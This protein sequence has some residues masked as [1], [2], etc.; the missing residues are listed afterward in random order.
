[1]GAD[2]PVQTP[3][4]D[5][6]LREASALTSAL[7]RARVVRRLL[8]LAV[9]IFV[10]A[11]G[12]AIYNEANHFMSPKYRDDL[13]NVAQE[14]LKAN[15]DKYMHHVQDLYEKNYPI[16]TEAF[17]TQAKQDM[18][19]FLQE[20]EKER[21]TLSD[22]LQAELQKRLDK[23]YET[24]VAK[25]QKTIEQELPGAK[26]E[27][28][29]EKMTKNLTL[30]VQKVSKKYYVDELH[31]QIET[32]FKTWDKFPPAEDPK[33]GEPSIDDQLL[34]ALLDVLKDMLAHG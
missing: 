34:P 31:A 10:A 27:K 22:R 2:E 30:A 7:S 5:A 13:M 3:E 28:M 25:H 16:I 26:D 33:P 20:I 14:R 32:L 11:L 6:V 29:R 21:G 1:M 18:P 24:L 8:L 17:Y 9:V 4:V 23:H 15:Q 19:K 12:Y